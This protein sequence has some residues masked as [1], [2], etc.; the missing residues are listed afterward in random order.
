MFHIKVYIATSPHVIQ[1][2][3]RARNL[4]FDPFSIA[5]T[6]NILGVAD[7]MRPV[8]TYLPENDKEVCYVTEL[9]KVYHEPL[10]PGPELQHINAQ[11]LRRIEE[12]LN[13]IGP[14]FQP[15][16]LYTWLRDSFTTA[17]AYSLY[18]PR[19]P[20]ALDSSLLERLWYVNAS[21]SNELLFVPIRIKVL[22]LSCFR[23]FE[24]D[25]PLLMM[26]FLPNFTARKAHKARNALQTSFR[27]YY[28][29]GYDLDDDVSP[30]IKRY[31]AVHKK[32]GF[33]NDDIGG[34][35]MAMILVA[36]TN[37]M[38]TLFWF[39]AYVLSDQK[40]TEELRSELSSAITSTTDEQGQESIVIDTAKFQE[41]CPL[42]I[43]AYQEAIRFSNAQMGIR[44]A[45]SDTVL[46]SADG[47]YLIKKGSV[48]ILP[49]GLLHTS[50]DVWG[51]D[52]QTFNARRWLK[53][54]TVANDN[55]SHSKDMEKLQKKA[56][57]PFG[58]GR[59]LCPGRHLAFIEILGMISIIVLG[60]DIVSADSEGGGPGGPVKVPKAQRRALGQALPKPVGDTN[61]FIKRKDGFEN[62]RWSF[63][64]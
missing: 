34:F 9:H 59:H 41:H 36:T 39:I 37:A 33:T 16:N 43:S 27:A 19:N 42:L 38:P 50:T 49:S 24:G 22:I 6:E 30:F 7:R 14:E 53:E 64:I 52:A 28:H 13:D 10:S 51:P 12:T 63:A 58:G 48:I 57:F 61:V 60:F 54:D 45:L 15:Q 47:T 18:G 46:T 4:S 25:I 31:T 5:F 56:F 8:V 40:L 62:A 23:E 1:S 55:P 17:V 11:V 20:I 35:T 3:L 32:Y 2:A 29:S 44:V 21:G 26:N